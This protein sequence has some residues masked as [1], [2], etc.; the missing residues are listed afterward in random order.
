[1]TWIVVTGFTCEA[2]AFTKSVPVFSRL[3]ERLGQRGANTESRPTC[4][5]YEL[6]IE[7]V[8]RNGE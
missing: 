7:R 3:A 4:V 1:M 8:K 5:G 2:G 6:Q